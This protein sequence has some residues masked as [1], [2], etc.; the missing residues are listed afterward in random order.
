MRFI[1]TANVA[2]PSRP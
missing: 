2:P 1:S